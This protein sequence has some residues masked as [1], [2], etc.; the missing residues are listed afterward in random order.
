MIIQVPPP[1]LQAESA[2]AND[3]LAAEM[4]A[5]NEKALVDHADA[6]ADADKKMRLILTKDDL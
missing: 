1:A 3:A 4:A 2:A 5:A 6:D